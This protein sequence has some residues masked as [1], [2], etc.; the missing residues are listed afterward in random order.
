[1]SKQE[2]SPR[3]ERFYTYYQP[4]SWSYQHTSNQPKKKDRRTAK[5]AILKRLALSLTIVLTII[6]AWLGWIS[7]TFLDHTTGFFGGT[8]LGNANKLLT[9]TALKGEDRGH[10]NILIVGNSVDDPGHSGADLT[11][12]IML[13]SIDPSNHKG[14]LLSIP[15][16]LYVDVPGVGHQ[17]INAAY[18]WGNVQK[19]QGPFYPSGGIGLLEKVVSDNLGI[20]ID[21]FML[22]NYSAL[23]NIVNVVGGIDIKINSSDPRG[24]FDPNISPVDEGPLKLSNGWH[25]LD[26]QTALNLARARGD[27]ANNGQVAYGFAGSDFTR[28]EHQRQIFAAL[29]PKLFSSKVL[30]NPHKV[31]QILDAL[32][33]NLKTDL[34]INEARRIAQFFK[35]TSM[36]NIKS[37]ALSDNNVQHLQSYT[38]YDGQAALIPAA[39]LD[40]FASIKHYITKLLSGV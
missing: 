23:R 31:E 21:Y 8:P 4:K 13:L 3:S 15:R 40:N 28:T 38:T 16:D 18:H 20:P 30:F 7:W 11:D 37:A 10:V 27:P 1:M 12:S 5:Q 9:P 29:E 35:D 2:P 24:L 39:G 33:G 17:K 22:V 32:D 36:Q 6:I 14:I 34:Q 26:G 25:H 19:F